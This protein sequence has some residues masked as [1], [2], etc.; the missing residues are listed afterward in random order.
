MRV[1]FVANGVMSFN[2]LWRKSIYNVKQR[3]TQSNNIIVNHV[4]TFT[5]YTSKI[6]K[7]S[8]CIL[9]KYVIVMGICLGKFK[10]CPFLSRPRTEVI[11]ACR[12]LRFFLRGDECHTYA[13]RNISYAPNPNLFCCGCR[14]VRKVV[15][16]ACLRLK[17]VLYRISPP[18]GASI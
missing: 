11:C 7:N 15:E 17:G 10:L 3:V 2:E 4:Y 12:N 8:D 13:G 6:W 1:M 5:R 14:C 16:I 9:C 18:R